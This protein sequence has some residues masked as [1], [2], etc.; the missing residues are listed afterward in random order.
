MKVIIISVFILLT[1]YALAN[2]KTTVTITSLTNGARSTVL[3]ACGTAT[4]IEGKKPLLV[5]AKHDASFYTTMTN[6]DGKWCVLILRWTNKG[7]VD[8]TA[9]TLTGE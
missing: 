7:E 8:A 9:T 1:Q 2:E 4:H 3:E 5:T 6:A